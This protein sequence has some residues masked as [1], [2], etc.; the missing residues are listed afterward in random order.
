M[1]NAR[2]RFTLIELLVVIAIIA[3]LAAMLLPALS[4]AREKARAISCVNNLKQLCLGG[5]LYAEDYGECIMPAVFRYS[6]TY[7][8]TWQ[9]LD[10]L[11]SED[12]FE[13]PSSTGHYLDTTTA[14]RGELSLGY[15][16]YFTPDT[17]FKKLGTVKEP[18]KAAF[19]ADTVN[20][21]TGSGYR[22]YEFSMSTRNCNVAEAIRTRHSNGANIGFGDGH[23]EK[24]MVGNI[25]SRDNIN[26]WGPAW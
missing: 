13:C 26:L 12:V 14:R 15:N 6:T 25:N 11:K 16:W 5:Q 7:L 24:R 8:W 4:Q 21:P 2:R 17:G 18:T 22:G 19:Y 10:Y 23:V 3:I 20:G 9:M 1:K